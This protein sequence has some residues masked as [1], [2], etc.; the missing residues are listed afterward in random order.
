M[1]PDTHATT[2]AEIWPWGLMSAPVP[3]LT[4]IVWPPSM[5]KLES[6]PL[7]K[8]LIPMQAPTPVTSP[9]DVKLPL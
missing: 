4:V 3:D 5:V 8:T 7:A 2:G 9:A 6:V 1:D